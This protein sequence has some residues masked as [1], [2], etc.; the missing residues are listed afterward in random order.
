MSMYDIYTL[1]TI[2]TTPIIAMQTRDAL[3]IYGF[4]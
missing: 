3:S 4:M 2:T 1:K